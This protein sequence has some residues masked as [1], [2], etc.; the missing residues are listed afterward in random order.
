MG[1]NFAEQDVTVVISLGQNVVGQEFRGAG[2]RGC[3]TQIGVKNENE[4]RTSR[5]LR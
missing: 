2:R 3:R 5:N 4:Y 1:Q